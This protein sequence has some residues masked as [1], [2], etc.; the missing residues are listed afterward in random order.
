VSF[1]DNL[2]QGSF[3]GVEFYTDTSALTSGR[4]AIQHEYP[5]RETPFTE[6]LGR[7]PENF[8]LEGHVIGESYFEAKENLLRVFT[9]EGPGEL[10]H[11]FWGS[12]FVQVGQITISESNLEGAIAKFSAKFYESGDNRF[13]K[14]S[15][16][17]GAILD[18]SVDQSIA[19]AQADF[20]EDFSIVGL[21]AFAVD[22]ARAAVELAS[23]TFNDVTKLGVTVAD[24]ATELAFKTRSLVAEVNDLLQAPNLLAQRL[25]DSFALLEES[26]DLAEDQA[27]AYGGF[28]NF[29]E[30]NVIGDTPVREQ[31]RKNQRALNNFIRRVAAA[32]AANSAA[33]G[34]YVSF[35]DA[36]AKREEISSMLEDQ[37]ALDDGTEVFQA[38]ADVKAQLID[39]LPDVDADLPNLKEITVESDTNSLLLTYDLFE[40]AD[41]EDDLIE[42]NG[43][44]NPAVIAAGTKLEVLDEG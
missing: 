38:L 14:G 27:D 11:P 18:Q 44:R 23:N 2:R 32:S 43:I 36:L 16:D 21:P 26:F 34:S 7:I 19:A 33:A 10:I 31:E 4:R 40:S 15:N 24:A 17:K 1:K 41:N 22:S 12:R 37:L 25:L 39:A 35:D 5:N 28:F 3:R 29:G 20:E 42:R 8:E 6:D 9:Q 30:D 13:P